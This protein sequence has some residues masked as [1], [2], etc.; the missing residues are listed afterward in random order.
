[1]NEW[2]TYSFDIV[3]AELQE[4]DSQIL[5]TQGQGGGTMNTLPAGTLP[6]PPVHS[7]AGH[8]HPSLSSQP[9]S[10]GSNGYGTFSITTA[11]TFT[12]T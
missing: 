4:L 2:M 10:L 12:T 3:Q 7:S 6:S 9:S 5:L 1:M 11:T 8:W